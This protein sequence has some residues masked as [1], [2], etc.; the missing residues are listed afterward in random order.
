MCPVLERT[1]A[2]V[3]YELLGAAITR[4]LRCNMRAGNSVPPWPSINTAKLKNCQTC[5]ENVIFQFHQASS[6]HSVKNLLSTPRS[7]NDR[8]TLKSFLF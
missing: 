7:Q 8:K 4:V 2:A 5:R 1:A 6:D 3:G